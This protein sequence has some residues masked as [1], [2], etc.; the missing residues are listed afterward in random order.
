MPN[1]NELKE[2]LADSPPIFGATA[3]LVKAPSNLKD[4][5][6]ELL[7]LSILHGDYPHTKTI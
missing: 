1:P 6:G 3:P 5:L 7:P 2:F 4:T